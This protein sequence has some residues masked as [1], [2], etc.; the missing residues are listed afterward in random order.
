VTDLTD[1]DCHL[2]FELGWVSLTPQA[3]GLCGILPRNGSDLSYSQSLSDCRCTADSIVQRLWPAAC[4]MLE[5]CPAHS[6][7]LSLRFEIC[8]K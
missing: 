6:G 3:V 4:R 1:L 7:Q 8:H 5:L 2:P